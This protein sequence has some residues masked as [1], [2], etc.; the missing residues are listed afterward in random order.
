MRTFAARRRWEPEV[1]FS[2]IELLNQ[3][4][5]QEQ[6]QLPHSTKNALN[7]PPVRRPP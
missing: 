7:G 1:F 3:K 6:G 4:Q 5:M 2:D